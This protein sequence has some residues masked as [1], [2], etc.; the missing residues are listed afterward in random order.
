MEFLDEQMLKDMKF[1]L[2]VLL[3]FIN[4]GLF[5]AMEYARETYNGLKKGYFSGSSKNRHHNH[6]NFQD[7]VHIHSDFLN[8][9][10]QFRSDGSY[11]VGSNPFN[12]IHSGPPHY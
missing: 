9:G 10:L 7:D 4:I 8:D 12:N 2:V 11:G 3:V 5:F 1:V 6:K